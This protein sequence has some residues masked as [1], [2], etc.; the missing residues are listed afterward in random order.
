MSGP[1]KQPGRVS[2]MRPELAHDS[3][4]VFGQRYKAIFSALAASNMNAVII[5]I[6]ITQLQIKR[7]GQAKPECIG[8]YNE[9]PGAQLSGAAHQELNLR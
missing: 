4:S 5:S 6:D 1:R 2:V 8:D 3:Q 9:D 7:L